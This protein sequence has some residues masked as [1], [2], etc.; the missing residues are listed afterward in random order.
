MLVYD[1]GQMRS[2]IAAMVPVLVVVACNSG[3]P[4]AV[5]NQPGCDLTTTG[6]LIGYTYDAATPAPTGGAIADGTYDL[7]KIIDHQRVSVAWSSNS[8]PAFRWSIRF[9]TEERSPN[10]AEGHLETAIDIPPANK[11]ESG[12]FATIDTS[13]RT[14]TKTR[15]ELEEI[16][17]AVT[18]A[19]LL[20]LTSGTTYVFRRR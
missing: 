15:P 6:P 8:A 10:H 18:P 17:Y 1:H 4:A 9:T 7:E 13:L 3:A 20:L 19:G 12:R 5:P 16:K 14:L 2:S 11:C